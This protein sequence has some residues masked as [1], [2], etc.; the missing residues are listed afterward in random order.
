MLHYELSQLGEEANWLV[1][2]HGAGGSIS[3]WNYQRKAFEPHFNLLLVDLRDHGKSKNLEPAH[4]HYN[5]EVVTR[6]ILK[7]IDAL[8]IG[9]A[10]FIS[11]SL[12]SII[13]QKLDELRPGLVEKMIAAGG[14]FKP[15]L[16]IHFFAHSGKILSYLLTYRQLYHLFSW[17][18]MPRKNHDKSRRLYRLHSE[19]L[20]QEEFLKWLGL[21]KGFFRELKHFFRRALTTPCLVVM[22]SQDHVFLDA[23]VEFVKRQP[24]AIL[25]VIENCGHI[26][27]VDN[28]ALFNSIALDFLLEQG[29]FKP[30][31]NPV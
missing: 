16:K 18:I 14:I 1:F 6:D 2:V 29:A 24:Q 13:L 12:G 4:Q 27:T 20:T 23:A 10:F 26:V 15:N 21:Y 30:K 7:V 28:P 8:G 22:G 3:T 11:L 17:V 9:K 25:K 31:Q 19:R 5:F